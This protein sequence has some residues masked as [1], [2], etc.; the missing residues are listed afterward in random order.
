[1]AAAF[2]G[3]ASDL[4]RQRPRRGARRA[5]VGRERAGRNDVAFHF[6]LPVRKVHES[7]GVGVGGSPTNVPSSARQSNTSRNPIFSAVRWAILQRRPARMTTDSQGG[8]MTTSRFAVAALVALLTPSPRR[9]R[10]ETARV[11]VAPESKLWIEGTSNL[12]GWS[13]KA[14]KLEA[15]IDLDAAAAAQLDRGAAQGAQARAGQSAGQVAQVR[16]RRDGRQPL[17]GAQ[18]RRHAGDQLHPR[19][20]RGGPGRDE[21][22]VHPAH[23]RHAHRRRQGEQDRRWTSRRPDL[24]TAP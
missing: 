2:R 1:M 21:G 13:C 17:Q 14:E 16:P 15:E 22:H 4:H 19:D 20:V 23:G 24:P 5:H 18:R 10:Q 9:L 7:R 8:R 3:S 6:T 12:H 11:A